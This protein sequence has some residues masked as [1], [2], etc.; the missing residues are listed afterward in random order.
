MHDG[1]GGSRTADT[2]TAPTHRSMLLQLPQTMLV[3]PVW[4]LVTLV[5]AAV[6]VA[7]LVC[8]LVA[9][10]EMMERHGIVRPMIDPQNAMNK[11]ISSGLTHMLSNAKGGTIFKTRT[12]VDPEMALCVQPA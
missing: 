9:L 4:N 3:A 12:F 7:Q 11:S 6:V 2:R 1:C 10:Y 5:V 8:F